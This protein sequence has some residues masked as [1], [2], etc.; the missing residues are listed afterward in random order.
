MFKK[1]LFNEASD[2]TSQGGPSAA[3]A[4]SASPAASITQGTPSN[5]TTAIDA[6]YG[7]KPQ[8]TKVEPAQ[9]GVPAK[10]TDATPASGYE[11]P[12]AGDTTGYKPPEGDKLPTEETTEPPKTEAS[13]D[14]AGLSKDQI[15]GIKNF[16]AANKLS[17]EAAAEYV[18]LAKGFKTQVESYEKERT[19]KI[20]QNIEKRKSE[21]FNELK[22][23]KEFGGQNFDVNLKKVDVVLDRF[24]PNTKKE[25]TTNKSMLPPSTMRDLQALHKALL[26][27]EGTLVTPNTVGADQGDEFT[28]FLNTQYK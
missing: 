19:A 3:P 8:E 21:W 20:Q 2:T 22:Q 6:M 27:S 5:D 7:Q 15:I 12:P 24:F 25:L 17:K 26:G 23:D 11:A 16:I 28:K 9:E 4:Q 10:A 14:E 13:F 1:L 18:N